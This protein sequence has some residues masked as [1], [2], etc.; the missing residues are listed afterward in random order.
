MTRYI[1]SALLITASIL[2]SYDI[3]KLIASQDPDAVYPNATAVNI[4]TE[5]TYDIKDDYSYEHKV[6]YLKKILDYSGKIRYSD[7]DI[8]Y[9]PDHESVEL[10]NYYTVSPEN[11]KIPVPENQIYDLN[12]DESVWSP[13]YIHNRK[14]IINFPQIGPGYYIVLEYKIV[15][16]RKL[17][18]SGIEHFQESNPYLEKILNIN[19]PKKLNIKYYADPALEFTKKEGDVI[20]LSWRAKDVPLIKS[21]PSSPDYLYSGRPVMFSFFKDWKEFNKNEFS[22]I[23]PKSGSKEVRELAEKLTSGLKTEKEKVYAL[24]EYLAKNFTAKQSYIAS[25][26]FKPEDLSK[27]IERKFGSSRDLT[28]LFIALAES[29]GIKNC[30]PAIRLGRDFSLIKNRMKD[31]VLY[32]SFDEFVIHYDGALFEIGN[33]H[34][35]YGYAGGFIS[36]VLLPDK[37]GPVEVILP[38]NKTISRKY[39]YEI[40][41]SDI[42]ISLESVNTGMFDSWMRSFESFPESERGMRFFQWVIRDNTAEL[43]EGPVFT[44]FGNLNKDMKVSYSIKKP[45]G[46]VKQ[47]EYS[48]FYLSDAAMNFDV[49]LS[50]RENDFYVPDRMIYKDEFEIGAGKDM[51][52]INL[53]NKDLK[54]KTGDKEAYIRI[55]IKRAEGKVIITRETYMPEMLI[56]KEKYPEFRDFIMVLKKPINSMVFFK[57]I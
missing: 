51:E 16:T 42:N 28:A 35:P 3:D 4:F 41:G 36:T 32:D 10:I 20:R 27:I 56:P 57:K 22:K 9:N 17:Q 6:F 44:N 15:S 18:V 53:E 47:G 13:E 45:S 34:Q 50:K 43:I 12:T 33:V 19:Y 11:V 7:V 1:L 49:S 30:R 52:L 5:V 25:M 8:E 31:L 39:K 38:E 55:N 21:E 26:D 37:T 40:S 23:Y 29:A 54:F 46:V 14:K 24:Y 48:Y 2:F